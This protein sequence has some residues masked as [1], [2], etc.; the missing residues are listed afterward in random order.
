MGTKLPP[1]HPEGIFGSKA[2]NYKGVARAIKK[3]EY[4]CFEF[5]TLEE[6]VRGVDFIHKT[7][8]SNKKGNISVDINE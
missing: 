8:E 6:G 3:G 1:G 2:N 7:M 4:R 5:P